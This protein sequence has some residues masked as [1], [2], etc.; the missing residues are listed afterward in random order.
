MTVRTR[1]STLTGNH[2]LLELLLRAAAIGI[3]SFAILGLLPA[4]AN[5]AG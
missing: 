4:I 2:P 1:F 3:V 5:G